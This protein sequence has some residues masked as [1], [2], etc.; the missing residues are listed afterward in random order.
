MKGEGEF[1]VGP[2]NKTV[3]LQVTPQHLARQQTN[4]NKYSHSFN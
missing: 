4:V 1:G 2:V 3:N